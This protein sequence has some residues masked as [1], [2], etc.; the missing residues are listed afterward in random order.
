[1]EKISAKYSNAQPFYK[2]ASKVFDI[3]GDLFANTINWHLFE[4]NASTVC[5]QVHFHEKNN[6]KIEE[7]LTL[8][9]SWKKYN[10]VP[11]V[12]WMANF[13]FLCTM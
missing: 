5:V 8:I 12:F 11:L 2:G 4:S 7:H 10:K 6:M 1:M 3:I 9:K 13:L